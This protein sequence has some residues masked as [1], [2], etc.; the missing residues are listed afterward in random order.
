MFFPRLLEIDGTQQMGVLVRKLPEGVNDVTKKAR[1]H[2]IPVHRN[3][4]LE[5]VR[6]H[7]SRAGNPQT[8]AGWVGWASKKLMAG[9]VGKQKTAQVTRGCSTITTHDDGAQ[10][11]RL[12]QQKDKMDALVKARTKFFANA[13]AEEQIEKKRLEL[14]KAQAV[15]TERVENSDSDQHSSVDEDS[16]SEQRASKAASKAKAA[17]KT[18]FK[19]TKGIETF[20]SVTTTASSKSI[21][22]SSK[23][24][25]AA[26]P[27]SGKWKGG[28]LGSLPAPPKTSSTGEVAEDICPLADDLSGKPKSRGRPPKAAGSV[29]DFLKSLDFNKWVKSYEEAVVIL[30][31]DPSDRWALLPVTPKGS[32]VFQ[33]TCKEALDG[34]KEVVAKV[35]KISDTA[36]RRNSKPD[37]AMDEFKPLLR[38]SSLLLGLFE[39]CLLN[40]K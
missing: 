16:D 19:T 29:G 33:E 17:A 34:F 11:V 39:A 22:T 12:G 32:K 27:G 5:A 35:K 3:P 2:D 14:E 10:N 26:K 18:S 15:P 31:E 30:N 1:Q 36:M 20:L 38:N 6:N 23:S 28:S 7:M 21:A 9:W 40:K 8:K 37:G 24:A 4:L 13:V 25:S